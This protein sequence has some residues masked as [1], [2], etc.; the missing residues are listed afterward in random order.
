MGDELKVLAIQT[1]QAAPGPIDWEALLDRSVK[2]YDAVSQFG[3][4]IYRFNYGEI[5]RQYAESIGKDGL[6][7]LERQQAILNAIL[8]QGS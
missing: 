1:Q 2:G 5:F 6:T 7:R 3:D 4:R 8:E